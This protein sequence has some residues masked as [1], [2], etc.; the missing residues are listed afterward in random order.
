MADSC[1]AVQV[2]SGRDVTLDALRGLAIVL[3]LTA[4]LTVVGFSPVPG[5]RLALGMQLAI[6]LFY[7]VVTQIAVP[8]FMLVSLYL[9]CRKRL[10][11]GPGYFV[12]RMRR[13]GAIFGAWVGLQYVAHWL[14]I[15]SAPI[16]LRTI[17]LGGPSLYGA[18]ASV[19]YFL[20]DLILMVAGFELL[21]QLNESGHGRTVD[22]LSWAGMAA[23]LAFFAWMD[24]SGRLVDHWLM[25]NFVPYLAFAAMVFLRGTR[26]P[27]W[28]GWALLVGGVMLDLYVVFSVAD[29][30]IWSLS[31]Y[32]RWSVVGASL[33]AWQL[34]RP[35]LAGAPGW[36]GR[37]GALSLGIY[38]V[39]D[40]YKFAFTDALEPL[41]IA[42]RWGTLSLNLAMTCAV[43][44]A[45]VLTVL[46]LDRTPLRWMVR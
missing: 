19:L 26:I 38:A 30:T 17:A 16:T 35:R 14:L 15:G 25:V 18:E 37:I 45:T 31:S 7:K 11:T 8:S 44:G 23:S 22:V 34:L 2:P 27:A 39:H 20:F 36:L 42:I 43:V 28:F 32:A 1:N 12:S 10:E 4:H 24:V 21:V 13:L 6:G 9:Y 41:V 5:S 40:Y 46:V 3:V 29:W 33:V